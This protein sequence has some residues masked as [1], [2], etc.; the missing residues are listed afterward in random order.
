M[1]TLPRAREQLAEELR[2]AARGGPPFA[3]PND[4]SAR[5]ALDDPGCVPTFVGMIDGRTAIAKHTKWIG[6]LLF[7]L[8]AATIALEALG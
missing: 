3:S 5:A 7:V 2:A 4:E 1:R 6:Y 8:L